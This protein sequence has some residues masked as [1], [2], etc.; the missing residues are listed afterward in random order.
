MTDS[1]AQ[2]RVK[3][4]MRHTYTWRQNLDPDNPLPPNVVGTNGHAV[5]FAASFSGTPPYE[6]D[7]NEAWGVQDGIYGPPI[8]GKM[9]IYHDAGEQLDTTTGEIIRVRPIIRVP[10]DDPITD[11]DLVME[12]KDGTGIVLISGPLRV[13]VDM[14]YAPHG[15]L[16]YR[17]ILLRE[18]LVE[19]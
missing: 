9:C 1:F 5:P 19:D 15:P 18:T 13:M 6:A 8:A 7:V 10:W 2:G 17:T 4:F 11:N 16:L 3:W 12:V 14:Q